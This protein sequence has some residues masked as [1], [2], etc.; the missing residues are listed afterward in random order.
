M[1]RCHQEVVRGFRETVSVCHGELG[2][3][4][5]LAIELDL[6]D[7]TVVVAKPGGPAKESCLFL[8]APD[9]KRYC[10]RVGE[11]IPEPDEFC[12]AGCLCPNGLVLLP[13]LERQKTCRQLRK[14]TDLRAKW[15]LYPEL[16]V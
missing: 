10:G 3:R 16:E 12:R 15:R 2:G 13:R 14:K 11:M 9:Q 4:V 7:E 6:P 1:F 5:Q 8:L